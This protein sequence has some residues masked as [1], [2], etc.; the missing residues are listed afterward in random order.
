MVNI[1][2]LTLKGIK[3]EDS[4]YNSFEIAKVKASVVIS[5]KGAIIT[6]PDQILG[7]R[8]KKFFDEVF[9]K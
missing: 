8:L 5:E 1:V 9:E 6:F 3:R 7:E 2:T 4:G